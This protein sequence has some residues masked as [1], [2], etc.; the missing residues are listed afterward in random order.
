MDRSPSGAQALPP[1]SWRSR[2]DDDREGGPTDQACRLQRLRV[3]HGSSRWR[4]RGHSARGSIPGDRKVGGP[5]AQPE[6]QVPG[7]LRC[8]TP[9]TGVAGQM[10]GGGRAQASEFVPSHQLSRLSLGLSAACA[11]CTALLADRGRYLLLLVQEICGPDVQSPGR[12]PERQQRSILLAAFDKAYICS[13]HTHALG[14]CFLAETRLE[15][16][17][18][19]ICAEYIANIHPQDRKQL[20][21]LALRIKIPGATHTV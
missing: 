4:T 20:C 12:M 10:Q 2:R 14:Q 21:I 1:S 17:G 8:G 9:C 18:A 7:P 5:A 15:P 11:S 16:E 3:C 13:I 6:G 19:K